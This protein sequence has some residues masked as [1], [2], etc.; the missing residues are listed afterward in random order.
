MPYSLKKNE[1][2]K[3]PSLLYQILRELAPLHLHLI[4]FSLQLFNI[5]LLEPIG[6][7]ILGNIVLCQQTANGKYVMVFRQIGCFNSIEFKGYINILISLA[8][9]KILI[10]HDKGLYHR[11]WSSEVAG[12]NFI[13]YILTILVYWGYSNIYRVQSDNNKETKPYHN[14][15][16]SKACSEAQESNIL[17][18]IIFLFLKRKILYVW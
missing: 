1:E 3:Q 4:F 11:C 18:S 6:S 14:I 10:S 17:W 12:E 5:P 16:R 7:W 15:N 8:K 13:N 9:K 2:K